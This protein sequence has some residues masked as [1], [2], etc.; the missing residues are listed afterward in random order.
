MQRAS[1]RDVLRV[2]PLG[3][4]TAGLPS[5][6]VAASP[7]SGP[8]GPSALA[9]YTFDGNGHLEVASD[10]SGLDLGTNEYTLELWYRLDTRDR[11]AVAHEQL[12]FLDYLHPTFGFGGYPI[13]LYLEPTTTAQDGDVT[14]CQLQVSSGNAGLQVWVPFDE[15]WHHLALVRFGFGASTQLLLFGDGALLI[16]TPPLSSY[17]FDFGAPASPVAIGAALSYWVDDGTGSLTHDGYATPSHRLVGSVSNVR[18]IR[19]Q[20]RYLLEFTPPEPPLE[21]VS[22]GGLVSTP[23]LMLADGLLAESSASERIITVDGTGVGVS[24]TDVPA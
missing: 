6:A 16:E 23:L 22:D 18:L 7:G 20:P 17:A 14:L 3:I 15:G 10:G 5:S 9:S 12:L 21:A 4:V 11:S 1:R 2:G 24:T 8:L 19:G 13:E